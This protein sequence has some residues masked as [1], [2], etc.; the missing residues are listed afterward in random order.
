MTQEMNQSFEKVVAMVKTIYERNLLPSFAEMMTFSVFTFEKHW[1]TTLPPSIRAFNIWMH[2]HPDV[3]VK[4]YSNLD[5]NKKIIL[6]DFNKVSSFTFGELT[7][8]PDYDKF[9][10]V[11]ATIQPIFTEWEDINRNQQKLMDQLRQS[12]EHLDFQNIGN[13]AHT[14]LQQLADIVFDP[15]RHVP[16]DTKIDVSPGKFKNRL[17]TY[18]EIELKG[19]HNAELRKFVDAQIT[20]MEKTIDLA[21]TTTHKLDVE[22]PFAEACVVGTI[23]VISVIKVIHKKKI[24]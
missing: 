7:I 1:N 4:Y 3:Y 14:I 20:A 15:A 9:I 12:G 19:S 8:L 13:T 10:L 23:S 11:D 18:I 22:W 6:R 21:N 16:S 2:M 5:S 17:H 24:V